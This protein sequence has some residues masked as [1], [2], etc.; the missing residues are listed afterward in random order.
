M[1]PNQVTSDD[2]HLESV[3]LIRV[4]SGEKFHERREK[5]KKLT[6]FLSVFDCSSEYS[7]RW[8]ECGSQLTSEW[9]VKF[10]FLSFSSSLLSLS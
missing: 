9:N 4:H 10:V 5:K 6:V 8:M 7:R 3:S 1:P 2:Q